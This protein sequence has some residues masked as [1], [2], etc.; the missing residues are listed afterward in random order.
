M[1]KHD[2]K[3]FNL[4]SGDELDFILIYARQY[5]KQYIKQHNCNNK[6]KLFDLGVKLSSLSYYVNNLKSLYNP[7]FPPSLSEKEITNYFTRIEKDFPNIFKFMF[8]EYD[9]YLL[10]LDQF[11]IYEFCQQLG[12]YAY[13]QKYNRVINDWDKE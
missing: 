9:K 3:S 5:I 8:D 13:A 12:Y 1:A 4:Y 7:I 10:T 11:E 2:Y 6:I